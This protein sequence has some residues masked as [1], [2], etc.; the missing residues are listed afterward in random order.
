MT[1]QIP[2]WVQYLQALSTPAIAL[3]AAVI[4]VLQ[5]RTAHQRAV[6]DLFDRRMQNYDALNAAIAEIMR[7]GTASFE[8]VVAFSRAADRARFLFGKDVSPYLQQTR[9]LIVN[10]RKAEL[11]AR[12]EDDEKRAKGADLEAECLTTITEFYE[13]F[14]AMVRPYMRMHQKAPWF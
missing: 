2:M 6:L 5:W 9:D 3:L 1:N 14:F 11:A 10:L 7:E 13:E 8:S 4:G 12:S